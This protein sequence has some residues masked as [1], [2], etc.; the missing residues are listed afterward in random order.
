MNPVDFPSRDEFD[1]DA[2]EQMHPDVAA[3]IAAGIV[4]SGWQH[5]LLHGHRERR[6][7]P[8]Q[9]N[10]LAGVLTEISPQDE[11]HRANPEHYYDVGESAR[12][13]IEHALS[14]VHRPPETV[15]RIL[16]LPCGHGRVLRFLRAAFP[17]AELSACDL[18]RDG[19]EFCAKAFGAQPIHSD[20][21]PRR[22]PLNRDYDLIWCGSLLTH[23]SEPNCVNFLEVFHDALAPGGLAVVTLHGRHFADDLASGR[24][25]GDLSTA[26]IAELVRQYRASGFG[27][28]NYPAT[29]DYGFSLTHPSCTFTRLVA[30]RPWRVADYRESAWDRRQDVLVLQKKR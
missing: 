26:G 17:Q 9:P 5:Y 24:R 12:R 18:N 1:S 20:P 4:A 14:S 13:V 2:Y 15:H 3:A 19:V 10:R 30:T 21:D 23:L 8:R 16:D 22:V 27:Y 28:V 25:T 7:W 29:P 11:M 6:A